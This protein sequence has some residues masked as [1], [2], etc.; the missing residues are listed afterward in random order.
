MIYKTLSLTQPWASLVA[1][2][3][4]VFETRS[5]YSPHRGPIAI[6]AS[7]GFPKDC[8]MLCHEEP[9][10]E[11]LLSIGISRIDQLP[12]GAV[13][14]TGTMRGCYKMGSLYAPCAAD[15]FRHFR[16]PMHPEF[17]FGDFSDGRYAWLLE[18]VVKLPEPI[19]A[20]GSLGL[21]RWDDGANAVQPGR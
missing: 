11:A 2:A 7:A 4:K 1:Y 12:L 9:F 18:D 20:K 3:L 6:H 8:K 14:A 19:P 10:T 5:W 13:L 15:L 16:V 17:S 21:W